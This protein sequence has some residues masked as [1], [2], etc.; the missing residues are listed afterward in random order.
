MLQLSS[1]LDLREIRKD[2]SKESPAMMGQENE[3][4]SSSFL[5]LRLLF[6]S[7]LRPSFLHPPPFFNRNR[8][9]LVDG[10]FFVV[11]CLLYAVQLGLNGGLFVPSRTDVNK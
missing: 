4:S 8:A 5:F 2:Q 9:S 10:R 7:F 11:L 1:A 3:P 6:L